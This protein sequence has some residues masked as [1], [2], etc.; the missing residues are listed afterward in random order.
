M[1]R[2][3]LVILGVAAA[4]VTGVVVP[5]FAQSSPVTVGVSTNDGVAVGVGING[6]PGVGARVSNGQAC[7]GVSLE[8]PYCT[9]QVTI[10]TPRARQSLPV[11]PVGVYHDDTRTAVVVGEVGVVI[12]SNGR[13]CPGVSTQDWPCVGVELG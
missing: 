10:A 12:Y 5:T 7:F 6:E 2:R 9:P 11:L 3:R 8:V 13:I 4:A 1:S